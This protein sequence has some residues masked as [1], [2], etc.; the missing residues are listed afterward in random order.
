MFYYKREKYI[1]GVKI[2]LC[3]CAIVKLKEFEL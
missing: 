1:F 3:E 2:C